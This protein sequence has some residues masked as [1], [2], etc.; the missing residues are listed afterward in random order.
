MHARAKCRLQ[1]R[2]M[3]GLLSCAVGLSLLVSRVS[4]SHLDRDFHSA[5][6]L[7]QSRQ[8]ARAERVLR[9]LLNQAPKSYRMNELMGLVC[10]VQ[11]KPKEANPY[12][13]TAVKLKP[14]SAEA[15][16]NL[17]EDLVMLHLT[18]EAE[19]EFRKAVALAPQDFT[20]NHDLGEF[21]IRSGRFRDAIP[22]LVRAEQID[23][24]SGS[25]GHDLALAEID[26]GRYEQ[27]RAEI[28]RLL[29]KQN[30]ADLRS[31]LATVDEKTRRYIEAG[32]EF[33]RVANMDPSEA[34][35]FAWGLELLQHQALQSATQVFSR[36]V[37]LYPKSTRLYLGLGIALSGQVLYR[38]AIDSFCRAIDLHPDDP[39]PYSFLWRIYNISPTEASAVTARFRR[40]AQ[41]RP[42][43]PKAL[44]YYAMSLCKTFRSAPTAARVRKVKTLLD[45]AIALS[46]KFAQPHLLLGSLFAQ[47]KQYGAAI[48][49]YRDALRRDPQLAEAHYG[50]GEALMRIGDRKDAEE[51][52]A[53]FS[54]V[55]QRELQRQDRLR[56]EIKQFVIP[57]PTPVS[58][59]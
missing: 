10:A 24:S 22:Y 48:E 15:H 46:P 34:N 50:L 49:Q 47:Q 37:Q 14:A 55:R 20:A 52:F 5:M 9:Q 8:Y 59:P 32:N 21:Y 17:A 12:L 7:Y 44:Y 19:Q 25:N 6:M 40:F 58:K 29:A 38:R 3:F 33:E 36:G 28:L 51:E 54:R 16:T 27:A 31:L 35:I 23:P 43:N 4:A 26:T 18:S 57:P 45:R 53:I 42:D 11:N 41:L 13:F 1:A 30:T 39:R 2:M 56:K